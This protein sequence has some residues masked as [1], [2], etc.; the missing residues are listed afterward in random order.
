M[1]PA[2]FQSGQFQS[3]IETGFPFLAARVMNTKLFAE[4]IQ[5]GVVVEQL[6]GTLFW[7]SAVNFFD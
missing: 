2:E 3:V 6:S 4:T 1:C 5:L 7:A